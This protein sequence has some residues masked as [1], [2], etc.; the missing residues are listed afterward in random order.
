MKTLL[1]VAAG[2][3]VGTNSAWA[4]DWSTV[5]SANFSSAPSGMTYSV[6]NGSTNIDNG[7][8]SYH[9]GGGSGDRAIKTAFTDAAFSVDTNWKMEFDWNCSSSNQNSSNVAFATN[10]GTAFTITWAN[11]SSTATVTDAS[12]TELTSTLPHLGYNKGTCGGWSHITI[13]GDTEMEY[14]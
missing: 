4:D 14:I 1:L 9:Q 3:C 12:A 5:W 7:Y 6:T 10:N 8:L 11:G 2:L 13:T